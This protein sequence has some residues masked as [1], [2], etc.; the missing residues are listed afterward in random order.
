MALSGVGEGSQTYA[1]H[2]HCGGGC[3]DQF[4]IFPAIYFG[5]TTG[6]NV[7]FNPQAMKIKIRLLWTAVVLPCWGSPDGPKKQKSVLCRPLFSIPVKS[8]HFA[9]VLLASS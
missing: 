1:F 4:E 7:N 6:T 5:G 3:W 9:F 2:V 8:L